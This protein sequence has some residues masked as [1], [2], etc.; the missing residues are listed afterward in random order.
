MNPEKKIKELTNSKSELLYIPYEEAYENGFE[1]MQRRAPDLSKI[2]K[3]IGYKPQ[4]NLDKTLKM[5]IEHF[6]NN[7]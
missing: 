6:K 5:V 7:L 3:L 4:Y 2:S 1:D